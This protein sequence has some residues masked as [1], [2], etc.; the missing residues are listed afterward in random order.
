MRFI[1][2]ERTRL[3][4]PKMPGRP[5]GVERV[6][7]HGYAVGS[8]HGDEVVQLRDAR[9][10]RGVRG[11]RQVRLSSQNVVDEGREV[12]ARTDLDEDADSIAVHRLYRLPKTNRARPLFDRLA[13]NGR[14]LR[15]VRPARGAGVQRALGRTDL[16]GLEELFQLLAEGLEQ[17]RVVGPAEGQRRTDRTFPLE[18]VSSLPDR[19]IR[20]EDDH[21][22]R[23]VVHRQM[24]P[25]VAALDQRAHER[26]I[27]SA[28]RQ[29]NA[30]LDVSPGGDPLIQLIQ[31]DHVANQALSGLD[32][33]GAPRHEGGIF[34]R[35]VADDRIGFD[36]E[37]LQEAVQGLVGCKNRLR[38]II[39]LPESVLGF[40]IRAGRR[41]NDLAG[42]P[43]SLPGKR[44]V[45]E[46]EPRPHF[47]KVYAKIVQHVRVL[48]A[49]AGKEKRK[50]S[51]PVERLLEEI[52]TLRILNARA[53]GIG[54]AFQRPVEL[55]YQRLRRAGHESETIGRSPRRRVERVG[56]IL[57]HHVRRSG[58]I[59]PELL[60]LHDERLPRVG[61][62]QER[63]RLP[64]MLQLGLPGF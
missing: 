19:F 22:M 47:G 36:M 38:P 45:E 24:K 49:L 53:A 14:R 30:F 5:P 33:T 7:L 52:D 50:R 16:E 6:E 62:E 26:G 39:H 3:V 55:L 4:Q 44:P 41:E 46:I 42:K 54:E 20:S 8:Q 57:Q 12:V 56:E 23:A 34:S 17:G 59:V 15:R 25:P 1:L 2:I 51:L 61:L 35:A 37:R 28:D 40:R 27:R 48:R 43:L 32:R 64:E 9:S 31:G 13:P 21:L 29:Q 11:N 60:G 58:C 18:H 10:S 63:F